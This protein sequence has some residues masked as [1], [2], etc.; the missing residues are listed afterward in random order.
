M[1]V[2]VAAAVSAARPAVAQKLYGQFEV[3]YQHL[4]GV[5]TG[6]V[7]ERWI[8]SFETDYST[9]LPSAVDLLARVKLSQQTIAGRQDRLRT[10]EGSLRVAHRNFG[11]FTEYR[12]TEVRDFLGM[13]T[14]QQTLTFTGYAQKPGLPSLSGS[15]IRSHYTANTLAPGTATVT[16]NLAAI[17]TMRH[18]G[19]HGGYGDRSLEADSGFSSRTEE[20]HGTA[21]AVSQFQLGKAPVALQYDFTQSWVDPSGRRTQISRLH[22]ASMNS[23]VQWT[24]KT[25]SGF[26]YTYRR[27]D[28][29]GLPGNRVE[30]HNGSASISQIL[31]RAWSVSAGAGVRSAVLSGRTLTERFVTAGTGAQAQARRGWTMGASAARTMNWLPG[32][33][34]RATDAASANSAMRFA[35]GL[36]A[37][38]DFSISATDQ[39]VLADSLGAGRVIGRQFGLGL[40]AV[41]LRTV[42]LD[43]SVHRAHTGTSG[44]RG[45]SSATSY[46][47]TVRITPSARLQL[48]SGWSETVGFLTRGTTV[49][50]TVL[51]SPSSRLQASGTYNRAHQSI[52]ETVTVPI[53]SGQESFTGA[54]SMGLARNLNVS[55]RYSD[56]YRG[57]PGQAREW[58]V[59]LVKRFGT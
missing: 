56:S 15:W 55:A 17:H 10:P 49:N 19:L 29:V 47:A 31:T 27:A 6:A 57:Q 48:S 44:I 9:R 20:R 53:V 3:Q 41:P 58:S 28:V 24:R 46:A 36:D 43:G 51:W 37:R 34:W 45:S 26:N 23:S 14:H 59:D 2:A 11:L 50:A 25:S 42:F 40:T 1:A 5:A 39:P 13:T 7:R 22:T 32:D 18:L 30:D 21:G 33:R 4:E 54:V 12:P 16:R 38:G 52:S 8:T 35:Q